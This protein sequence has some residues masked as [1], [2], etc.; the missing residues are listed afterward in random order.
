MDPKMAAYCQAVRD[1]EGKF[2][3]HE[4]HHVLRDYNN[5][6]DML[7]KT[8]S[9]RKPVPHRVFASGQHAPSVREEA[10]K[11]RGRSRQKKKNPKSW[12]LTNHPS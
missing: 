7:V 2:H 1:S 10:E 6:T 12:Q 4:L 8:T 3:G 9:S 11:Q 5:A